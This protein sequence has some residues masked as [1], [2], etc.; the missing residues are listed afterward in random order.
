[1]GNVIDDSFMSLG[2]KND[3]LL[4]I[5]RISL[6]AAQ[7]VIGGPK[8]EYRELFTLDPVVKVTTE[9]VEMNETLFALLVMGCSHSLDVCRET[10]G[11]MAVFE[12]RIECKE[13][14]NFAVRTIAD[15]PLGIGKCVEIEP[16]NRSN[17]SS[18]QWYFAVDGTLHL[19]VPSQSD[20]Q[21]ANGSSEVAVLDGYNNS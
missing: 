20:P 15:F 14:L 19:R 9:V 4:V 6:G 1:M 3:Y 21:Q 18:A 13:E 16:Q 17:L 2:K 7:V 8:A 12:S 5:Y 11:D 10:P